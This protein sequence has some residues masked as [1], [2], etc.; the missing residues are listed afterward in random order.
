MLKHSPYFKSECE[1]LAWGD[2]DIRHCNLH[3]EV[4]TQT[5]THKAPLSLDNAL[6]MGGIV[7]HLVL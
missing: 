2:N 4:H 6:I 5:H 7:S 3:I 1:S